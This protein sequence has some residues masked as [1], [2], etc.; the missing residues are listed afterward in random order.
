MHELEALQAFAR[1]LLKAWERE[2]ALCPALPVKFREF[3]QVVP[4]QLCHN[5]EMLLKIEIVIQL[6]KV[7]FVPSIVRV[8][9]L[10]D[11]D[12]IERLVK[13]ILV[14]LD[15]LDAN[16]R[17]IRQVDALHRFTESCCTKK[18]KDLQRRS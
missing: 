1:D 14:V 3:I 10:E 15:Y 2:V 13:E 5:E 9:V 18:F 17:P 4:Q 6:Q 8:Y 7:V 16:I 11:L 12:L